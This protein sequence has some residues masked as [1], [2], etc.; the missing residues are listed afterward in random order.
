MRA[1]AA[2]HPELP[3]P[4]ATLAPLQFLIRSTWSTSAAY[5][6]AAWFEGV[7]SV[8]ARARTWP[9]RAGRITGH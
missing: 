1:I 6:W 7:L 3:D 4:P 9:A 5:A 2:D 8:A